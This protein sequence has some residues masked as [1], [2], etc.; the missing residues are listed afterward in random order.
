ML[1]S[2][3]E[4]GQHKIFHHYF[5]EFMQALAAVMVKTQKGEAYS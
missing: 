1:A 5:D 2:A 4:H 3:W